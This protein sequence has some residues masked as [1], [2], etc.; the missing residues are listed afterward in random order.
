MEAYLLIINLQHAEE[1]L[2]VEEDKRNEM[3]AK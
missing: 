2:H 1:H 3:I